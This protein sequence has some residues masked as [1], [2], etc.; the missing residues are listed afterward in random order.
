MLCV[1][2]VCPS[3]GHWSEAQYMAKF[4]LGGFPRAVNMLGRSSRRFG[5]GDSSIKHVLTFEATDSKQSH[6]YWSLVGSMF[7]GVGIMFSFP[8]D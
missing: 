1:C 2:R 4:N 6:S 5:L 7:E 3:H 8:P